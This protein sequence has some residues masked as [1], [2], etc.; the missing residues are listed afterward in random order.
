MEKLVAAPGDDGSSDNSD[1]AIVYAVVR[2]TGVR[3]IH[4][5]LEHRGRTAADVKVTVDL[6]LEVTDEA[7]RNLDVVH[8]RAMHP[9][10]QT[11]SRG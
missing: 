8:R 2:V 6:G 1:E 9:N 3:S 4:I 11:G 10:S 7:M 5:C